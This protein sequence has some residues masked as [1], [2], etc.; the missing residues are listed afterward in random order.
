MKTLVVA[1]AFCSL[2]L[3][4]GS[5]AASSTDADLVASVRVVVGRCLEQPMSLSI[6]AA[7]REAARLTVLRST[8]QRGAPTVD[9][10]PLEVPQV[11]PVV[12][13]APR[14]SSRLICLSSDD[15]A[16]RAEAPSL[17]PSR[18]E[19]ARLDH[20]F[21]PSPSLPRVHPA[22]SRDVVRITSV[23]AVVRPG[24]VPAPW[25]PPRG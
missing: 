14:P 4:G 16:C 24:H 22:V 12:P 8:T 2:L 7:E 9:D 13:A 19:L 11:D 20:G 1:A 6:Q 25:R 5:A 18:V 3:V 15:S 23:V 17:P 10:A 21:A